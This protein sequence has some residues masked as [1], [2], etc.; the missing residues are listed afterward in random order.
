MSPAGWT[1]AEKTLL[2]RLVGHAHAAM[3]TAMGDMLAT[4]V[5]E[6]GRECGTPPQEIARAQGWWREAAAR[7]A[8]RARRRRR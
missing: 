4:L 1:R 8:A 6:V 2:K 3:Y 5:G 7:C